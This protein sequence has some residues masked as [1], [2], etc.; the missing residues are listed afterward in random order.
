MPLRVIIPPKDRSPDASSARR[1]AFLGWVVGSGLCLALWPAGAGSAPFAPES[2]ASVSEPALGSAPTAAQPTPTPAAETPVESPTSPP[3]PSAP[4]PEAQPQTAPAAP[5]TRPRETL[6]FPSDDL[7]APLMADPKDLHFFGSLLRSRAPGAGVQST[8]AAIGFGE[9]FGVWGQRGAR[10]GWQLGIQTGVLAQLNLAPITAYGLINAD[11]LA[12]VAATWRSG[13]LSGRL[14]VY[15]QS[16]HLG[17]SFLIEN[18]AAP[19]L[20][21]SFEELEVLIAHDVA[22]ERGRVYAGGALLVHRHPQLDRRRLQLGFEWHGWRASGASV[23]G[24]RLRA[25][26]VVGVD[27]RS[28]GQMHWRLNLRAVAGV[29]LARPHGRRGVSLLA[30]YYEG[31]FPYGQFFEQKV[32]SFGVGVH[33]ML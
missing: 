17:D 28:V 32:H 5:A 18:P 19:R 26:P 2:G 7:F 24:E 8:M 1:W 14:R 13:R 12:G 10:S 21:V 29:E 33:L 27:L 15:H 11:Y 25:A 3:P 16:S 31:Y 22:H 9:D 4:S 20:N 6:T 23:F 30:D